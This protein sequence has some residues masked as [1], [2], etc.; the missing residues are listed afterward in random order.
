MPDADDLQYY[1]SRLCGLG[2][3][4]IT[5]HSE[6]IPEDFNDSLLSTMSDAPTNFPSNDLETDIH[7]NVRR[8]EYNNYIKQLCEMERTRSKLK[9]F[10]KREE[11][12]G[13]ENEVIHTDPHSRNMRK[14]AWVQEIL[15]SLNPDKDYEDALELSVVNPDP[16]LPLAW[17]MSPSIEKVR[18]TYGSRI[19]L[20]QALGMKWENLVGT[21]LYPDLVIGRRVSISN[22]TFQ[23]EASNT[24]LKSIIDWYLFSQNATITDGISSWIHE[25]EREINLFLT[26]IRRVKIHETH[27]TQKYESNGHILNIVSIIENQH[28]VSSKEDTTIQPISAELFHKYMKFVFSALNIPKDEYTELDSYRKTI[29]RWERSSFGFR[30]KVDPYIK[31]WK[32]TWVLIMRDKITA[33]NVSVFLRVLEAWDPIETHFLTPSQRLMLC[34]D[35]IAMYLQTQMVR[36]ERAAVRSSVLYERVAKWCFHYLPQEFFSSSITAMQ[37]SPE[38]AKVGCVAKRLGDGRWTCGIKFKDEL[39]GIGSHAEP[40]QPDSQR[41]LFKSRKKAKDSDAPQ[42]PEPE[43]KKTVK[44]KDV[45]EATATEVNL[46]KI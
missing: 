13:K 37:I 30:P 4:K 32:D 45:T 11:K 27:V 14:R 9:V 35:F 26:A 24:F 44:K 40:L 38:F 43:P 23:H 7:D 1:Y 39:T 41:S 28:L 33:E 10:A 2:D 21:D 3:V 15:K 18:E 16:Y 6:P 8:E 20:D 42:E 12:H 46:G 17:I 5:L 19:I 31:N 36:D 29:A 34:R 22:W 25:A